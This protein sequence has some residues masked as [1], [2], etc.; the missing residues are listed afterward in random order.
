MKKVL[1]FGLT[2]FF[3]GSL[4]AQDS[5]SY[6]SI[7]GGSINMRYQREESNFSD[8]EEQRFDWDASL[9]LNPY[10]V[11]QLSNRMGVG[12]QGSYLIS[13][14]KSITQFASEE[15]GWQKYTFHSLRSQVFMRYD[16]VQFNRFQAF[17]QPHLRGAYRWRSYQR[18]GEPREERDPS[19]T[20]AVGVQPGIAVRVTDHI[21]LV[22]FLGSVYYQIGQTRSNATMEWLDLR[23]DFYAGFGL[24]NI[25][26]SMEYRW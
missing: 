23:S 25:G 7:F 4:L 21:W 10:Y 13:S 26:F 18:N 11:W 9:G 20:M 8:E 1:F 15:I 5:L 24:S 19:W 16:L 3:A 14:S 6:T 2:L 12:V 22:G 17:L